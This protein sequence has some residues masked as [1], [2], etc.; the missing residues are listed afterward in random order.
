MVITE[1]YLEEQLLYAKLV[2]QSRSRYQQLCLWQRQY[3]SV[4]KYKFKYE[5][6]DECVLLGSVPGNENYS[7]LSNFQPITD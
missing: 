1:T 5:Y 7:A 6:C 3:V 4:Y 2:C